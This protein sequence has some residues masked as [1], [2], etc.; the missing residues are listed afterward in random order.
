MPHSVL[1]WHHSHVLHK[2]CQFAVLVD[3]GQERLS[4]P[5]MEWRV[6]RAVGPQPE[7]TA[8]AQRNN[9]TMGASAAP[10]STLP[11]FSDESA[12]PGAVT[13]IRSAQP[14]YRVRERASGSARAPSGLEAQ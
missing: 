11:P 8:L 5:V 4:T 3:F 14:A 12:E 2:Q 13:Q 1:P 9:E 10:G 6:G 7:V